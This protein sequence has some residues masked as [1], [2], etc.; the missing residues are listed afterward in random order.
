MKVLAYWAAR[1]GL[2]FGLVAILALVG[3]WD[4]ISVVAAFLMA[5]LLSY[6]VLPGMRRTASVQLDGWIGRFQARHH[7]DDADEDAEADI[8]RGVEPS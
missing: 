1:M 4:V 2:F 7:V 5:W 6:I 8:A 3:W